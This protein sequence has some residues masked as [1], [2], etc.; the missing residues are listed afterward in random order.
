MDATSFESID[1]SQNSKNLCNGGISIFHPL[2][3]TESRINVAKIL[4][5]LS[6]LVCSTMSPI[7]WHLDFLF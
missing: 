6:H 3:F 2:F 1:Q 5:G 7:F 4:E